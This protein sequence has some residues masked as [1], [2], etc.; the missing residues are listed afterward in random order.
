MTD[1][2]LYDDIIMDHIK[3]ARNYGMLCNADHEA[4]GKS[5]L[6]G[7]EM[8]VR[9]KLDAER[10]GSVTFQCTCCGISMASASIM[11]ETL[12]GRPVDEARMLSRDF[13]ALLGDRARPSSQ[14]LSPEWLA[15]LETV[16]KFPARMPCAGVPWVTLEAALDGRE[17][18]IVVR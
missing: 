5:P 1:T 14:P 2:L 13:V 15:I 17:E 10:I 9:V 4:T 6:C 11:T 18:A 16:G 7:D 8:L 3:N 12:I